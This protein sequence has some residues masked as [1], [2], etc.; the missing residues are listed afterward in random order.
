[1]DSY[2]VEAVSLAERRG[3]VLK[4]TL[5]IFEWMN[6][7]RLAC[8]SRYLKVNERDY[9]FTKLNNYQTYELAHFLKY[10]NNQLAVS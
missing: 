2:I 10:V 4:L 7:V 6:W 1:M 8:L 9:K 3:Y 5:I